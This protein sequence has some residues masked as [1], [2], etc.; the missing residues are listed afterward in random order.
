[1]LCCSFFIYF[2]H[3]VL[4]KNS[5]QISFV[6]H[7]TSYI[8]IIGLVY[9]FFPFD[10]MERYL[11]FFSIVHY[12][13]RVYACNTLVPFFHLVKVHISCFFY[14]LKEHSQVWDNFWRLKALLKWWKILFVSPQKVFSSSRYLN[15][16]IE[17][18]IMW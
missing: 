10:S 7:H 15:F 1:M 14:F 5:Q 6:T 13:Y 17:F 11:C 3:N 12:I 2:I 16:C 18:L 4:T 8:T 9:N